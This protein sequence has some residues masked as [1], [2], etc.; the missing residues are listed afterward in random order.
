MINSENPQC[1][2]RTQGILIV[3]FWKSL[4]THQTWFVRIRV[5]EKGVTFCFKARR[6]FS[7][8]ERLAKLPF[9]STS[10]EKHLEQ[11]KQV[12]GGSWVNGFGF[13][14]KLFAPRVK[15]QFLSYVFKNELVWEI[16]G[17]FSVGIHDCWKFRLAHE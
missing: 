5:G 16:Q 13:G 14:L 1:F 4:L 2:G 15:F 9:S 7:E 8:V 11:L 12:N 3:F 10:D 17:I 6:F